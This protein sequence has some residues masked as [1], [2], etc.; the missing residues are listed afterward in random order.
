MDC[1]RETT[2]SLH[3]QTQF[4]IDLMVF[5]AVYCSEIAPAPPEHLTVKVLSVLAQNGANYLRWFKYTNQPVLYSIPV[6]CIRELFWKS[7]N[8]LLM[9]THVV[10]TKKN[11]EVFLLFN[12][13]QMVCGACVSGN[14][15][16]VLHCTWAARATPRPARILRP[17]EGR[18]WG[19]NESKDKARESFKSC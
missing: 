14:D 15:Y 5:G 16:V 19:K 8:H 11:H 12:T 18:V 1:V 9:W 17:R 10:S 7:C 4:V 2:Q 3:L 6:V 13:E